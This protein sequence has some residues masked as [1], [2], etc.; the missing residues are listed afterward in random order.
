MTDAVK[1]GLR[2]RAGTHDELPEVLA[3]RAAEIT[4]DA[5]PEMEMNVDGELIG[6]RTPVTF[7]IEGQTTIRV[8]AER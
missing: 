7:R 6:V 5:E 4:I 2:V 1:L 3:L 8:P